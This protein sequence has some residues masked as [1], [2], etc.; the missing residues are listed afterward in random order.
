MEFLSYLNTCLILLCSILLQARCDVNAQDFDGWSPL[1]GAAHWGQLEASKL[2]VE[3]GCDMDMKNYAV[4]MRL[5]LLHNC[6]RIRSFFFIVVISLDYN[7]GQLGL[8]PS[9]LV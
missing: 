3:N 4:R 1:H 2:L 9:S 5:F 6:S 7:S 8:V